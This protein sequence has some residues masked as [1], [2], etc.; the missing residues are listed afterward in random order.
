[1]KHLKYGLRLTF[2]QR[3]TIKEQNL[4]LGEALLNLIDI[5]INIL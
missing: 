1:M 4:F 2:T 5:Y 3:S